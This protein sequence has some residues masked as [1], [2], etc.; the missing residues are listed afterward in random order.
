MARPFY[1]YLCRE[2]GDL[3]IKTMD[4]TFNDSRLLAY[5]SLTNPIPEFNNLNVVDLALNGN[6]IFFIAHPCCQRSMRERWFGNIKIKSYGYKLF[7]VPEFLKVSK[8]VF[9]LAIWQQ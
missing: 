8:D 1:P 2:F 6:N 5:H 3:A 9:A 7:N 4:R